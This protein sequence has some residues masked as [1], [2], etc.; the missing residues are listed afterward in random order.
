MKSGSQKIKGI[1]TGKY[2]YY[3]VLR[4]GLSDLFKD[5][6]DDIDIDNEIKL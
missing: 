5:A 1:K 2:N 3:T 4:A 6:S